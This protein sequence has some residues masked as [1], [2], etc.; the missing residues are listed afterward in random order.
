[1]TDAKARKNKEARTAFTRYQRIA[2]VELPIPVG[3]YATARYFL[4]E[5]YR[6]TGRKHQLRRHMKHIMH[7]I[8][9]DTKY[10]RTEHNNLFGHHYDCHRLMLAAT[11][12]QL[13]HPVSGASLAL[14]AISGFE[15]ILK[16]N[17]SG[18][19]KNL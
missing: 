14:E 17:R 13:P 8:V 9:G 1:M 3:R 15:P 19:N 6:Q 2:T 5:R 11:G 10:G 16:K 12:M 4:V 18:L 7:P